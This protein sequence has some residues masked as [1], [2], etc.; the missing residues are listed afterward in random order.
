MNSRLGTSSLRTRRCIKRTLES[1]RFNPSKAG[2][3][4][5]AG[6]CLGRHL[7]TSLRAC[8]ARCYALVHFA[9]TLAIVSAFLADLSAFPAGVPMMW[10][11]DQ[12]EMGG[13]PTHFGAGHH[14]PEMRRL[15]MLTAH[16]EAMVHRRAGACFVA[17]E[18]SLYAMGH[19]F[20]LH[21]DSFNPCRSNTAGVLGRELSCRYFWLQMWPDAL[22]LVNSDRARVPCSSV[23]PGSSRQV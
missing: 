16:F 6:A 4:L 11:A 18:T 19:F 15:N 1:P 5:R 20:R 7:A 12:H 10:G 22:D 21:C 8:P 17:C 2:K 9:Q 23:A 13:G 14:E 3:G